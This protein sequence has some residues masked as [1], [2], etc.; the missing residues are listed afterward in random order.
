MVTRRVQI[1][2]TGLRG[3]ERKLDQIFDRLKEPKE[4]LIRATNRVAKEWG[5]NF[6]SEGGRV[7]GWP[8]LAEMTRDI[9]EYQG[10]PP[11]RPIMLRYGALRAIAVEYF[12]NAKR[13]GRAAKGDNYSDE[14]VKGS[15]EIT[16][17]TATLRVGDSW[18]VANQWGF[19]NSATGQQVPARPF[20]FV[21][22]RAVA[23]AK[24]GVMDWLE[25]EVLR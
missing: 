21:D 16:R 8:E 23:A 19:T 18:K 15:L 1:R 25:D 14:T 9:R 5:D 4:G 11:D 10:F 12:E 6:D 22:R 3:V 17:G 20:W 13:E 2:V 7:G 24:E